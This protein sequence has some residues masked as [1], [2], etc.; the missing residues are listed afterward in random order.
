MEWVE[1]TGRSL[2]DALDLAL[3]QLG[4][5]E[6]EVEYEVLVEPK[7]GL[8]GKFGG[9]DARIRARVK[10]LSREK[11]GERRRNR[12]ERGR[13]PKQSST[14]P[15]GSNT[16]PARSPQ[17]AP[18]QSTPAGSS[19]S[20]SSSNRRRRSSGRKPAQ[21]EGPT[22]ST[23]EPTISVD[24]QAVIAVDFVRGVVDAFET[25]ATVTSKLEDDDV[26]LVDVTGSDLGLL[27]GPRG[28]T[29]TALEE[30]V[31]TVLQRHSGGHGARIHVD[32]AGY[33]AKRREALA[34]FTQELVERVLE[35]G[36]E[37]VLEPMPAADRKV[38][39]DTVATF[40][41]VAT[42]SEG[43]EPRRRVVI[44]KV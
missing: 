2:A 6:D 34:A 12:R 44:R 15:S 1:A 18:S 31:R 11:P 41:G 7:S 32:V 25:G 28:A 19:G 13:T 4:V 38:V 40:D 33:R 16:K 8:F 14:E 9:T 42:G 29:V 17:S 36:R 22:V 3:D 30:L 27:V 5:D 39:H 37:Q 21:P 10:P 43:E 24:E 35:S 26:I 20:S 23:Q